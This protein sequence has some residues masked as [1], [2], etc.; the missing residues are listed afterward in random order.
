MVYPQK[1]VFQGYK[2]SHFP[3]IILFQHSI[4]V[5]CAMWDKAKSKGPGVSGNWDLGH[6]EKKLDLYKK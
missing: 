3:V 2:Q 1:D 6:G 4:T 5:V